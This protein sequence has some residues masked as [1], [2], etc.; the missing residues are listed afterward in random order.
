[1]TESEIEAE[2]YNRNTGETKTRNILACDLIA[3]LKRIG[4]KDP[5]KNKKAKLQEIT[6]L[7]HSLVQ[8]KKPVIH[9]GWVGKS[10]GALQILFE[11]GWIDLS[12][13]AK[14]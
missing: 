9:E 14:K 8:Y 12:E 3:E 6:K 7:H 5:P 2:R 11:R 1:M 13:R 10:K 4:V